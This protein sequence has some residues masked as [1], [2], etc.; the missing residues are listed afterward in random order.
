ME[1]AFLSSKITVDADC[2]HEIKRCLLLRRKAMTNLDSVL[3]SR[4]T[5]LQ[6]KVYVLKVILFPVYLWELDQESPAVKNWCL[7]IVVL[8]KTLEGP[9]NCKEIKPVNTKGNQPWIFTGRTDAT[10]ESPILWPPDKKSWFTG[11]D[12][13]FGRRR[14]WRMGW[15]DSITDSM[16]I[17][18]RKLWEIVR[19]SLVGY[20]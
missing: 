13:A 9:L 8:E 2:S 14:W 20:Q 1:T 16:D 10:I 18:L 17:N 11:E 4:D 12:P 6:T 3:K 19:A 5:T 15:L 7:K